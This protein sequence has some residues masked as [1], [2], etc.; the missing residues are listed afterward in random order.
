MSFNEWA[1]RGIKKFDYFD[2]GWIKFSS[3]AFIL[4]IAK[5]WSPILSLD[6]YWYLILFILFAIK[7]IIKMLKN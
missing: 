6:W 5:I 3:M 7:P 1:N 4:L 2:V